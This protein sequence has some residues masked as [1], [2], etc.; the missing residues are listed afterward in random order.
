MLVFIAVVQW[1]VFLW[2]LW[3]YER[4]SMRNPKMLCKACLCSSCRNCT[5]A[6]HLHLITMQDSQCCG[7]QD[8]QCRG[9]SLFLAA[10]LWVTQR[11]FLVIWESCDHFSLLSRCSWRPGKESFSSLCI[12]VKRSFPGRHS[13][14][15]SRSLFLPFARFIICVSFSRFLG[16]ENL[17]STSHT[18]NI[19]VT[20]TYV[21]T[22]THSYNTSFSRSNTL[23]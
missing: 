2:G 20:I 14:V 17:S 10:T 4:M 5:I 12:R 8:S 19:I 11:Y 15:S 6:I 9:V 3:F 23:N 18:L 16:D 22:V 13:A 1:E 21:H 7:V